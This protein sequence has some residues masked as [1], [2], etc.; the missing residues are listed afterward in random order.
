MSVRPKINIPLTLSDKVI[1]ALAII[2]LL[3][4]WMMVVY[5]YSSL[6][7]TIPIHYNGKGE[8]DSFGG[9]LSIFAMPMVATVIYFGLTVLSRFPHLFNY[10]TEI[11]AENAVSQYTNAIRLFR[12][13]KLVIIFVFGLGSYQTIQDALGKTDGLGSWY[14]PVTIG[15]ILAVVIYFLIR[16]AEPGHR[17]RPWW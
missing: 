1:E 4:Y 5:F 7:E 3:A 14:L 13:L 10:A 6:P 17:K 15:L 12:Y 11:T 2:L 9:K 16:S 8:A